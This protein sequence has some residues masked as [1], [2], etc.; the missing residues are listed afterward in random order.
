MAIIYRPV[1]ETVLMENFI[2]L[3]RDNDIASNLSQNK[4]N[5]MA[6]NSNMFKGVCFA[7]CT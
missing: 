3:L 5:I 1:L 2:P 7:K 6:F 4:F